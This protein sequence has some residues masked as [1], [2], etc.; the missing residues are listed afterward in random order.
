MGPGDPVLLNLNVAPPDEG[1]AIVIPP[2]EYSVKATG[3][4]EA[5]RAVKPRLNRERSAFRGVAVFPQGEPAAVVCSQGG[6]SGIKPTKDFAVASNVREAGLDGPKSKRRVLGFLIKLAE[7]P[8]IELNVLL[9][10]G[11]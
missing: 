11:V 8:L 3:A 6:G 2:P 1:N 7:C 10:P 9:S 5:W 4:I